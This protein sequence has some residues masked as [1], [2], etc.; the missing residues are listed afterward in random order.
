MT[1]DRDLPGEP[2]WAPPGR[3]H[4]GSVGCVRE[5]PAHHHLTDRQVGPRLIL[6]GGLAP[7]YLVKSP[8]PEPKEHMGTTD[9]DMVIEVEIDIRGPRA[10]AVAPAHT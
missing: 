1:T 3:V 4:A 9:L 6:F 10:G 7:R 8:P 2:P 5:G